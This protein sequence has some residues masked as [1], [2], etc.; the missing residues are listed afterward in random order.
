MSDAPGTIA[1][2]EPAGDG[3]NAFIRLAQRPRLMLMMLAGWSVLSVLAET[4]TSNGIF[5]ENHLAIQGEGT[6]ELE[7]D[8]ALG[9]LALGWQGIP[10]AALYVY[11]FFDPPR[12]RPVFFLALLHMGTLAAAQLYHWLITSDFTFESIIVPLAG[13]AALAALVF[14]HLFQAREEPPARHPADEHRAH[15]SA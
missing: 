3:G 10:L 7:L 4:F 15:E 12:F 5:L 14:V 6:L 13:S 9:G 1:R 8:G 11:C 2:V